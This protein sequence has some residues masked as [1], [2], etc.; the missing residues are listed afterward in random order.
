MAR[1]SYRQG[2]MR[3]LNRCAESKGLALWRGLVRAA[4]APGVRAALVNWGCLGGC[5]A[6]PRGDEGADDQDEKTEGL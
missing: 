5:A 4:P 2:Y 3:T 6:L 1:R